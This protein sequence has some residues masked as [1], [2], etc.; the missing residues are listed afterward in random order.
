[1]VM[2]IIGFIGTGIM[3]RSMA[4][5]LLNAG[6]SL[7][8]HTRTKAKADRLI[9]HGAEWK[10]SV[11]ELSADSDAV[12]SIVGSPDDVRNIYLGDDGVLNNAREGTFI[13]DMTTSDPRLAIEIHKSAIDR[14]MHAL[15][16]PVSGGDVGARNASL[17][18]MAGGDPGT[19]RRM[20][21]VFETMG[22]NI[23][24]MGPAG[25]GQHAKMVNQI[26]IATCMIGVCEALSYAR[27]SGLDGM[28]TLQCIESGAAGSWSLSNYGPRILNEDYSPGFSVKHF[29]KDMKIALDCAEDM[30]L[31]FRGLNLARE[32]YEKLAFEHGEDLGTHALYKVV[33]A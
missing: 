10:N 23:S 21:P 11:A 30:G 12:I 19:F 14:R 1:M 9:E 31:Q 32:L 28:D 25:S 20:L 24:H 22:R 26:A 7:S 2:K 29:I 27:H 18:I 16:A 13:V 4:F 5:H 33:Q 6:Y 3:G 15:D 17:T 8:V